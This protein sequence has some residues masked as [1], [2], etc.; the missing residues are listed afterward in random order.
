M[1]TGSPRNALFTGDRRAEYPCALGDSV[2]WLS[3]DAERA[4]ARIVTAALRGKPEIVL[5]PAARGVAAFAQG[6][7]PGLTQRL[8][9][10]ADRLLPCGEDASQPGPGH[11]AEPSPPA[12]L[13]VATRLTRSA[14]RRF[15][16]HQDPA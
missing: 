5:T 12:W 11:A 1:R 2:P 16:Q 14:A 13:R 9:G 6:V 3:M 7:A 15:H 4:A 10:A 8:A